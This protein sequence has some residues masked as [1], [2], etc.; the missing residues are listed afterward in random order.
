MSASIQSI[1]EFMKANLHRKLAL[2][3]I[4]QTVGLSHP[5]ICYLFKSEFGLSP[6]QYLKMLRMQKARELLEGTSISIKEIIAKV[7]IQDQSHFTRDFKKVYAV[8]PFKYR[9]RFAG[10]NLIGE[11]P[12]EAKS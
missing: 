8:T 6:G 7:G 12:G 10:E 11:G 5:H 3:E 2:G 1:V 9:E 4:A